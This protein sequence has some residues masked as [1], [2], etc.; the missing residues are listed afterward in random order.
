MGSDAEIEDGKEVRF[1][2]SPQMWAYLGWL[3][4]HTVLGRSEID[5]ARQLLTQRLAEMRQENFSDSN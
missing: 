2:A 3:A 5:V 1:K 4:K